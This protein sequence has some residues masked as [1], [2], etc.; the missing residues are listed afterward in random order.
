MLLK[1]LV[2]NL[3]HFHMPQHARV[4]CFTFLWT[5]VVLIVDIIF[6]W[7]LLVVGLNPSLCSMTSRW[8]GL[9][10]HISGSHHGRHLHLGIS[11]WGLIH[12][13]MA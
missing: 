6:A 9:A 12:H 5:L 11:S 13:C 2:V 4:A 7:V 10:R 3:I 8:F 1:K